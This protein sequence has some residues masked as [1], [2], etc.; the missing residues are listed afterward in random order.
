MV[1]I[2]MNYSSLCKWPFTLKMNFLHAGQ[3]VTKKYIFLTS[4][5]NGLLNNNAERKDL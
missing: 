5:K 4:T 2:I 3:M 1:I